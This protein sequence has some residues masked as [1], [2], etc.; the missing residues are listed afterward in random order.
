MADHPWHGWLERIVA[1]IETLPVADG[2]AVEGLTIRRL[3]RDPRPLHME[4][5]VGT[6]GARFEG[7]LPDGIAPEDLEVLEMVVDALEE[8][9]LKPLTWRPREGG[10]KRGRPPRPFSDFV[11]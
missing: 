11:E 5:W 9:G 3:A 6:D 10:E 2:R 4:V 7:S 1:L 8:E